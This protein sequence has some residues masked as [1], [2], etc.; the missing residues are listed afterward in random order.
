MSEEFAVEAELPL[1]SVGTRLARAREAAGLSRS[2]IAATTRI[3]ER[4]LAAIET[5]DFAA[6]PARTYAVGFARS[7]AKALGLDDKAIVEE[8]RAE[9]ADQAIEPPRRGIP[10]FEPGDPARV[11][12]ARLA[13]LSAL[14]VLVAVLIGYLAW[15]SLFAP[16]GTLPSIL[17]QETPSPAATAPAPAPSQAAPAGPVVF[18]AMEPDVWVKFYDGAGNQL[19]QKQLAQ[20]ETWTVPADQP[21]VLIWTARPDALAITIGG[22]AVPRLSDQQKTIKDV[23]VTA[24]ALL[25]RADPAAQP[26]APAASQAASAPPPAPRRAAPQRNRQPA[27]VQPGP[28]P[29]APAA[30][31]ASVPEP[32][33]APQPSAT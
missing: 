21:Q 29:A 1:E 18:T 26:P 4:H 32:A 9:L 23:P 30:T 20:G 16:G 19:L 2:Q 8:V 14:G 6:L 24:A 7:Y 25:A 3:P 27:A 17:P 12:S 13:W 10:T 22:Q 5:G 11:P 15:P 31:A 33:P 28:E